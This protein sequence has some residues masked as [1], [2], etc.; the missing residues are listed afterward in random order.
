[1]NKVLLDTNAIT[2]LFAGEHKVL[3]V[4]SN[5]RTVYLSVFV[6]GELY[7]G[8][9]GGTREDENRDILQQ[10]ISKPMVDILNANQE[11]ASVFA[12][13]KHQLKKSGKPIPIN[14]V[15]IAA[16]AME[17]GSVLLTYDT[18]FRYVAGLRVWPR[19]ADN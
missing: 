17:T 13:I 2:R 18:H 4:L 11:T 16:H 10:F 3:D 19:I 1:M 8:F 5:A 12:F 15:W 9:M 7:A 14:D 6:L